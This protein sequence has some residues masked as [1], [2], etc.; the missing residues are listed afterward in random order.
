MILKTIILVKLFKQNRNKIKQTK[1]KSIE[2]IKKK[3]LLTILSVIKSLTL[4][5][6]KSSNGRFF[7]FGKIFK[8]GCKI[9]TRDGYYILLKYYLINVLIKTKFFIRICSIDISLHIILPCLCEKCNETINYLISLL[10]LY[11]IINNMLFL[12]SAILLLELI[13]SYPLYSLI[14]VILV[15][16]QQLVKPRKILV[17]YYIIIGSD[18]N[19]V[20]LRSVL[21]AHATRFKMTQDGRQEGEWS[22]ARLSIAPCAAYCSIVSYSVRFPSFICENL[23]F[24]NSVRGTIV[25][26]SFTDSVVARFADTLKINII[27][28][29]PSYSCAC[30][31]LSISY[32]LLYFCVFLLLS[33]CLP[34]CYLLIT[35]FLAKYSI[36]FLTIPID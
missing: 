12:P 29:I 9:M 25:C 15:F 23:H 21:R 31:V 26:A 28:H 1:K 10:L 32:Q 17:L 35:S 11:I 5:L 3:F 16:S 20:F 36:E 18:K 8:K 30:K 34:C 2:N 27:K 19:N 24:R 13:E 33:V 4:K 22:A 6:E 14:F 7:R